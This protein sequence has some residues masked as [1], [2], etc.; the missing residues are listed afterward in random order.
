MP[1]L[2]EVETVRRGLEPAIVGR[3]IS[4]AIINRPNLRFA[5]PEHFSDRLESAQIIALRRRAKYLV[6]EL[7]TGEALIMHLGMSGRFT[8]YENERSQ[9]GHFHHVVKSAELHDHVVFQLD[10]GTV[11]IYNDP[12]RFGF[13]DLIPFNTLDQS[14]FFKGLGL[15]PLNGA[16]DG[17]ALLSLFQSKKTPL[18]SALLDQRL[19]AGLGNIYVCEAL[20]RAKLHPQKQAGTLTDAQAQDLAQAIVDV[21]QEAVEAGGSTLRD[22]AHADGSLGYFQHRFRV[23]DQEGK[24]CTEASCSGVINRVMLGG[25]STYFCATCQEE[26]IS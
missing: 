5:F 7:D 18:K 21:L 3:R 24:R 8:I 10:N 20:F 1:E 16:L 26:T 13:M 19:I 9:P 6:A 2:P 14:P 15:E 23:Y 4:R 17:S 22:F 12:R 11:I 25:R